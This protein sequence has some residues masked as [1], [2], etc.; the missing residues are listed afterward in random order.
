[1][2]RNWT[3][4]KKVGVGFVVTTVLAV[5]MG[6]LAVRGLV[7]LRDTMDQT[8]VECHDEVEARA[9]EAAEEETV[10]E[11]RAYLVAGDERH[12]KS[13]RDAEAQTAALYATMKKGVD[14]E[15]GRS[16]LAETEKT[17]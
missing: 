15:R 7:G 4:G 17:N 3:V 13:M 5:I 8:L 16:L 2:F 9:W 1:M 12:L 14:D 11:A 10:S 6:I